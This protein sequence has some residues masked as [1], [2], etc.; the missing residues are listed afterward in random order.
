MVC[1]YFACIQFGCISFS[2]SLVNSSKPRSTPTTEKP[3]YSYV[4]L[5]AM[6]IEVSIS[7]SSESLCFFLYDQHNS[8]IPFHLPKKKTNRILPSDEQRSAK[9]MLTL[10]QT[11]RTLKRIKKV[12]K[13]QFV[14]I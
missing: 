8:K 4:A 7:R 1:L 6:A 12:G 10:Q 11:F 13:I 14:T 3:P 2:N 9:F 5:I